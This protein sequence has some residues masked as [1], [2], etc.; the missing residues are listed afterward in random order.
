MS[1]VH[2]NCCGALCAEFGGHPFGMFCLKPGEEAD[3]ARLAVQHQ[4]QSA[5]MALSGLDL[6]MDA[7]LASETE[8]HRDAF[9]QL[10]SRTLAA[11]DELL[12]LAQPKPEEET[13]Q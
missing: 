3:I 9:T 2:E 8:C 12:A 13:N 6:D 11:F 7:W 1:A 4:L 5:R 10:R